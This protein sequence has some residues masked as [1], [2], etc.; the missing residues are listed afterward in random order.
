[1]QTLS[2]KITFV[3]AGLGYLLIH[4]GKA[5]GNGSIAVGTLMALMY[6]LPFVLGF[7]YL[8]VIFLRRA[9]GGQWPPWDRIL[10]IYFTIGILLGLISA[11]Y[12]QGDQER[13]RQEGKPV[14]ATRSG[15]D[16]GPKAP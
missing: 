11:L 1:M 4:L 8:V 16:A 14:T 6:T 9:T 10:R 3:L 12:I 15:Q 2:E 7:T 13:Q 5:P